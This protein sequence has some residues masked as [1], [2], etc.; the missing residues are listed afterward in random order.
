[1]SSPILDW[2]FKQIDLIKDMHFMFQKEFAYRCAGNRNTDSYGKLSVI[3]NYLCKVD[4]LA[5]ID[6]SYFDPVSKVDS[7][8]VRFKPKTNKKIQMNLKT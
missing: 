6:R 3:C 2:C 4:I 7:S 5:D 8:F 1:M